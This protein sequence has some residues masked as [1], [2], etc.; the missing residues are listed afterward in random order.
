MAL[1]TSGQGW[2]AG[3]QQGTPNLNRSDEP[4]TYP[5]TSSYT[6]GG[7]TVHAP[8]LHCPLCRLPPW[9]PI[10]TRACLGQGR[11]LGYRQLPVLGLQLLNV[12]LLFHGLEWG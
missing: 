1:P 11:G 12:Q 8:P 10:T 4:P 3:G 6:A 2:G 9:V 5:Q 7:L